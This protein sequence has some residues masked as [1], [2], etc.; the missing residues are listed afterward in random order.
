[1]FKYTKAAIDIIIEDIKKISNIFKYGSMIFT[2]L[3][4]IYAL[5]VSAGNFVVNAILLA[6]FTMYCLLDLITNK[7][8]FKLFKKVIR[9]SY[10]GL[11]LSSKLFS[12]GVMIYGIY[13]AS[14]NVN[15]VTIILATL[16]ILAWVFE[17]LFEIVIALFENKKD[18]LVEGWNKD[19]EDLKKPVTSV[20]NFIKKIKGE[21][22]VENNKVSKNIKILEKR[23]NKY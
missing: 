1:M 19:I 16:M 20:N 7:K 11:K 21:E 23:I 8:N 5:F 4:F 14:N 15:G 10:K 13:I 17:L 9:R 6:L 22:I 3:Y 12:L 18:L 2:I